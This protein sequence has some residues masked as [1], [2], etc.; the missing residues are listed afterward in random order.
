MFWYPVPAGVYRH[1]IN[2]PDNIKTATKLAH[3][4]LALLLH[5]NSFFMAVRTGLYFLVIRHA[6]H[7]QQCVFSYQLP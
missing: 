6:S 5:L 1:S 4:F 7:E 3:K 2:Y